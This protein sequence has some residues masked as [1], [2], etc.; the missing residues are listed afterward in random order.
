MSSTMPL[1]ISRMHSI[2]LESNQALDLLYRFLNEAVPM[3]LNSG[4]DESFLRGGKLIGT[5]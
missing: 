3:T 5:I 4:L 2:Q 1:F